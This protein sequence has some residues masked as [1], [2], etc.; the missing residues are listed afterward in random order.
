MCVLHRVQFR[1]WSIGKDLQHFGHIK[2]QIFSFL[3]PEMPCS[4]FTLRVSQKIDWETFAGFLFITGTDSASTAE[5]LKPHLR[6][7][8]II[9]QW[10]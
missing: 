8:F 7:P 2:L 6:S 9:Q 5:P 4:D 3:S 10:R 1:L